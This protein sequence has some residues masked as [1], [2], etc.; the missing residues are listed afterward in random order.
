MENVCHFRYSWAWR[1]SFITI[2]GKTFRKML[3]LQVI[4]WMQIF[5]SLNTVA[6]ILI[7]YSLQSGHQ[8]RNNRNF[9]SKFFTTSFFCINDIFS[10]LICLLT[11]VHDWC[12][13]GDDDHD[14]DDICAYLKFLYLFR[15]IFKYFLNYFVHY[16]I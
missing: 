12:M 4:Q 11:I 1:L 16:L 3:S 7:Q 13:M 9:L 15:N 14:D 10:L 2:P 5:K 6:T 8:L